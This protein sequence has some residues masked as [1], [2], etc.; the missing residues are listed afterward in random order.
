MGVARFLLRRILGGLAILPPLSV[1]VFAAIE[2]LPGDAAVYALAGQNPS[3]ELLAQTRHRL[4]LDR[5]APDRYLDWLAGLPHGDLGRSAINGQSVSAVIEGRI[6]NTVV[7]GVLVV[8]LMVPLA[9]GIGAFAGTREGRAGDRVLSLVTLCLV[10]VP[11]FVLAAA[12]IVV[13]AFALDVLPA[14][15]I[16]PV[17]DS[18]LAHPTVLV[19][20]VTTLALVAASGAARQV[21]VGVADVMRSRYVETARL[22][23][24]PERRVVLR[25]VIPNAVGP[26][27]QVLAGSVGVV[28]GGSV[29]VETVFSYPGLG[30]ALAAAVTT[31]DF[32]LVEG[33]VMLLAAALVVAYTAA[34]LAV[35][36]LTPK[37]RTAL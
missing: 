23:G 32:A 5:S 10:A 28:I 31:R 36:L 34:D 9:L 19:L 7:L 8:L 37:L 21:R 4:G 22:K 14:T 12:L 33:I 11:E 25:H 2:V 15:S 24:L 20:P 30:S 35:T 3:P 29:I 26:S 18:P 17:E 6:G 27:L 13:F 16:F 1:L